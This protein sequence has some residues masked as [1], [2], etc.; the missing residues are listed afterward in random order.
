M[1]RGF[2][3]PFKDIDRKLQVSTFLRLKPPL[4]QNPLPGCHLFP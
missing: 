1:F 4:P 3:L 2:D